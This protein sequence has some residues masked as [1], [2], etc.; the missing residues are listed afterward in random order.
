MA[1][2]LPATL[3]A[4]VSDVEKRSLRFF[5]MNVLLAVTLKNVLSG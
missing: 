5:M 4:V 3:W 1:S 2:F